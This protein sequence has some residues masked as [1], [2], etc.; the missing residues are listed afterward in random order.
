[1]VSG[2]QRRIRFRRSLR[3]HHQIGR[4]LHKVYSVDRLR[5]GRAF[6]GGTPRLHDRHHDGFNLV[7]FL[8]QFQQRAQGVIPKLRVVPGGHINPGAVFQI[9]DVKDLIHAVIHRGVVGAIGAGVHIG[10]IEAVFDEQL[11]LTPQQSEDIIDV[12]PHVIQHFVVVALWRLPVAGEPFCAEF[13]RL[14][15]LFGIGAGFLRRNRCGERHTPRTLSP[16]VHRTG[17]DG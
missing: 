10:K 1:M 2:F 15:A 8:L 9:D 5:S 12:H 17:A 4:E 14:G 6:D 7:P 3:I 16:S 11:A 13:M